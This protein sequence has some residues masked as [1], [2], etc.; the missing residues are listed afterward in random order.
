MSNTRE[1]GQAWSDEV[2]SRPDGY[3]QTWTQWIEGPNAQG[4]FDALVLQR[5]TGRTV[6]D[7]GCGDG[8][9]TL[10]VARVTAH[11][12]A[13]DFSGGMLD[14]ARRVVRNAGMTNVDFV[15]GHARRDAPPKAEHFDVAYSRRGPNITLVVPRTVKRGG[16]LL[17]LQPLRDAAGE[18]RYRLGL[19]ESRL[20]VVR[21]E[22]YDDVLCFPTLDDF[23]R[24]LSRVPGMPDFRRAE[25]AELLGAHAEQARR[26]DGTFGAPVHYLLWE[27]RRP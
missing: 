16:V 18:E 25:H 27:A 1:G 15:H 22:A 19:A 2:A 4:L 12:T 26:R 10:G 9:F 6:L 8:V 24:Y 13:L 11:V 17:G 20:D 7:C 21:F 23:T 3:R 5:A 14:Q